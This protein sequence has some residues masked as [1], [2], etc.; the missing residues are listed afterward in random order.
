MIDKLL[1]ETA[2]INKKYT[3]INQK[4]GVYFNVFD[5]LGVTADEVD[6]CKVLFELL[7]PNGRHCQ[8]DAYLK[9]FVKEVLRLDGFSEQDYESV[10]VSREKVYEVSGSK[11]RI[12]LFIETL[13]FRIPIEVKIFAGD[14]GK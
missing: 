10:Q 5:I 13:N 12:D 8:G 11:R 7:N 2:A 6:V 14:Q 1:L 3:I 9:L 4:T